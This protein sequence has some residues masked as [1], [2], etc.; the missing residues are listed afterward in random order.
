MH[1]W[2][3]EAVRPI[4]SELLVRSAREFRQLIDYV[5]HMKP[6]RQGLRLQEVRRGLRLIKEE[7]A[8]RGPAAEVPVHEAPEVAA[9]HWSYARREVIGPPEYKGR[10]GDAPPRKREKPAGRPEVSPQVHRDA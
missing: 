9:E 2:T 10:R 8:R 7:L 1:I 4:R 6:S 5:E 3:E